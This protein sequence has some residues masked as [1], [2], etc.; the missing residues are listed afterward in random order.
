MDAIP[1]GAK[2]EG[3]SVG[4]QRG[5]MR[6]PLGRLIA[7]PLSDLARAKLAVRPPRR[8][9]VRLPTRSAN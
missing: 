2:L 3:S 6:S 7:E 4:Q 1:D 8:A 5:E 9:R